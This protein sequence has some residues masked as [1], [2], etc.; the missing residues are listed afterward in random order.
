MGE[1]PK[2]S[3]TR[4]IEMDALAKDADKERLCCGKLLSPN[5]YGMR[6]CPLD[7]D[8]ISRAPFR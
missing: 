4:R 5:G 1:T 3:S 7:C 8:P 6:S 2:S